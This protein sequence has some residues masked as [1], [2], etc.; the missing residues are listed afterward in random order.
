[1]W[2]KIL[3]HNLEFIENFNNA[4]NRTYNLSINQF[5]DLT[6]EEFLASHTEYKPVL[7]Q[8]HPSNST[9]SDAVLMNVH[10]AWTGE[11]ARHCHSG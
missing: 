10:L 3:K 6:H 9:S 11:R 8:V 2:F 4:G 1:M 7:I 5:A